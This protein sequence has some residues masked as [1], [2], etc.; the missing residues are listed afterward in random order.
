MKAKHLFFA[1]SFALLAAACN[2]EEDPINNGDVNTDGAK[3]YTSV[4][5]KL[6]SAHKVTRAANLDDGTAGEY[7]VNDVTLIFFKVPEGKTAATTA[8]NEFVISD[9]LSTRTDLKSITG[10]LNTKVSEITGQTITTGPIEVSQASVRVVAIL[11]ISGIM[12][13]ANTVLQKSHTFGTLNGVQTLQDLSHLTGTSHDNFLMLSSPLWQTT[14][15]ETLATCTPQPTATAA[16]NNS[17]IIQ[18]ER[19]V[20]KVEVKAN[21]TNYTQA[22]DDTEKCFKVAN[23]SHTGDKIIIK[24]WALDI[25]NQKAFPFRIA[26]NWSTDYAKLWTG[27]MLDNSRIHWA[28]DPNYEGTNWSDETHKEFVTVNDVAD[29]AS[30]PTKVQ[31]CMENTCL[32]SNMNRSQVTRVVVKAKY[33][34]NANNQ[35][36]GENTFDTDGTWWS[37]SSVAAHYSKENICVQIINRLVSASGSENSYPTKPTATDL[38]VSIDGNGVLT[39]SGAG[40]SLTLTPLTGYDKTRLEVTSVTYN[41]GTDFPAQN[42]KSFNATTGYIQKYVG[43]ICYYPIYIRHFTNTEGGY[44]D[45]WNNPTGSYGVD[46]QGRYGVVRNNWYTVTINSISGP[47]DPEIPASPETPVDEQKAY[48]NCDITISKWAKR[49]QDEDL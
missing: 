18:V 22:A 41:N 27:A 10:I 12:A 16:Q 19:F 9:I 23:G 21:A 7:K 42:I 47:G 11:N 39:G 2:D 38:T 8:E 15:V 17:V 4:T 1:I 3:A 5:I 34:P 13:L 40:W 28:E 33:I 29:D 36:G 32:Y 30:W 6:P 35:E 25:Q 26:K 48:V 20:A 31:Y 14:K 24:G 45:D 49:N 44:G 37:F 43:G 46:Q